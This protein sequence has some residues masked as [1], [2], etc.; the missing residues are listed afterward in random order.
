VK[1]L[2]IFGG[3]EHDPL[4]PGLEEPTPPELIA[5]LTGRERRARVEFLVAQAHQIYQDALVAAGG[6]EIVGSVLCFSGGNDSTVLGHIFKDVATHAV[7]VRTG[8]GI[9]ETTQFVRDVTASWNLPLLVR[10]PPPGSTYEELVTEFGFPGPGFHYKM[11]QRLKERALRRVRKELVTNGRKQRVIFIAGRRRAESERR[12]DIPLLEHEDSIIWASPLALWTKLDM[13]T[14]RL[15]RGDVP[16]NQ[17]SELIGMSGE[18]LCGSFAKPGELEAVGAHFPAI[19]AHIQRLQDKLT[20]AGFTWPLNV[21]GHGQRVPSQGSS[22]E[23]GKFCTSCRTQ[24]PLWT[25]V[26]LEAARNASLDDAA[27]VP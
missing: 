14:Y 5:R 22:D 25:L 17:V 23:V 19:Q 20:A 12:K 16:T 4:R 13:I 24:D 15:M 2:E 21:W 9:E 8:I 18:C 1:Q 11:F 7:H 3:V 27:P 6:R 26:E 10:D